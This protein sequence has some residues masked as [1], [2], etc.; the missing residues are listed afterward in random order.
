LSRIRRGLYVAVPLDARRSGEWV[1]DAWVVADRVFSPCYIGGW[2]ACEYW[3]LTDQVFRTI[4]VVAH[5]SGPVG[6]VGVQGG[7]CLKRCY[8]ETYRF[9]E[10]LDFTVLPGGPFRPED[11]E[12]LPDLL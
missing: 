2:S 6:V 3:D 1:E 4:L 12:P 11:V 7:T 9:S 5:R 10:D 8:I